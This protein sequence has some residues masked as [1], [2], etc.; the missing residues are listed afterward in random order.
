[1]PQPILSFH[2]LGSFST[3]LANKSIAD[4]AFFV[5]TGSD[6]VVNWL[7]HVGSEIGKSAIKTCII[8]LR[9]VQVGR[10]VQKLF[11]KIGHS[12]VAGMLCV[13]AP[14]FG[15]PAP[16]RRTVG[17]GAKINM[18]DTLVSRHAVE[19]VVVIV[20]VHAFVEI[21]YLRISH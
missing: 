18:G 14:L 16:P 5:V 11:P 20:V 2:N 19:L 8:T 9:R 15:P 6:R 3:S 13:V 12:R 10:G 7:K 17:S 1:M 4:L 21:N